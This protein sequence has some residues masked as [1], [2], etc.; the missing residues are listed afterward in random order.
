M[1]NNKKYLFDDPRNVKR[2]L[3]ILYACCVV[4]LLLEFVIDRHVYHRW[5]N[6]WGFHP[7]Y[8]FVGCVLLVLIASWMRS[9]LMRPEDYYRDNNTDAGKQSGDANVDG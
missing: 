3:H 5:E 9:F 8:G 1:D 4:L 2:L 6:L 7:L